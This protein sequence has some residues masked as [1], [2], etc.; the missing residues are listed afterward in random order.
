MSDNAVNSLSGFKKEQMKVLISTSGRLK[1][2]GERHLDGNRWLRFLKL[3][4]VQSCSPKEIQVKFDKDEGLLY[5]VLPS[6]VPQHEYTPQPFPNTRAAFDE[7]Y[8]AMKAQQNLEDR[9]DV[10]AARR[11]DLAGESS[12]TQKFEK[13]MSNLMVGLRQ[14]KVAVGSVVIAIVVIAG[15]LAYLGY[16]YRSY[17]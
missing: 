4:T 5:V 3:Y 15:I 9:H 1:I 12:L 10:G 2:S 14:N 16:R 11:H 7:A 8:N 13:A 17:I 6:Q